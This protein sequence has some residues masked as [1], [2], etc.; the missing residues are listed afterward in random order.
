VRFQGTCY[1]G[2]DPR[3]AFDPLSGEGA[4]LKGGRFNRTGQAALYL[5]LKLEGLFLEMSHG[6]AH[7]FD[8]LTIC[9]YDVDASDIIDLRTNADCE[10]METTFEVL[11]CPWAL[12]IAEGRE[13]PSW[14]LTDGLLK[15]GAA[16]L[17]VPSFA[18]G[19]N[20]TLHHNLV[21]WKWGADLP[22]RVTVYDPSS[23]LS[24]D[25]SSWK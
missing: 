23:R 14:R 9:C 15:D 4:R 11:S 6:F 16:G 25:Q 20:P 24:H 17:L 10:K 3:W 19:A 18:H 1:R 22:Y 8:P 7:R 21:L 2:H 5:T 13:P 12:D